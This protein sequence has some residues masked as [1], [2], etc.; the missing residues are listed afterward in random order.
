MNNPTIADFLSTFNKI[1]SSFVNNDN[2]NIT[3]YSSVLKDTYNVLNSNERS[4]CFQY[5]SDFFNEQNDTYITIFFMSYLLK[6][7]NS[8]EAII[9]IQHTI[10]QSGISP[11]DALNIIFQMSSFSF[12]TD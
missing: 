12:S 4:T 3:L 5:I 9:H 7:L 10:S 1:I 6:T 8:A 2:E 11:I